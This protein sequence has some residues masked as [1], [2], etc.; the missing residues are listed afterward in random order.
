[1]SQKASQNH[2][3]ARWQCGKVA[4]WQGGRTICKVGRQ[5]EAE[6]RN[7]ELY[8]PETVFWFKSECVNNFCE[9]TIIDKRTATS[10][11]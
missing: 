1:M 3:W 7:K 5:K 4:R 2:A 6:T 9:N 11:F 10:V 8:K